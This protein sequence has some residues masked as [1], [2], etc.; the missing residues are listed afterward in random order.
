MFQG[1]DFGKRT[2][3]P[4]FNIRHKTVYRN[5]SCSYNSHDCRAASKNGHR[6]SHGFKSFS[7]YYIAACCSLY[8]TSIK[9]VF[10]SADYPFVYAFRAW[11]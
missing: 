2:E 6:H 5:S 8:F 9:F 7:F 3:R 10:V 1:G 4:V 11:A